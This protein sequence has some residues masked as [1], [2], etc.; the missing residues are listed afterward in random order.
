MVR[1]KLYPE[2][3]TKGSRKCGSKCCEVC[4]NVNE[5][6]TFTSTNSQIQIKSNSNHKF[7]YNGK[8][9]VS[10][11]TCNCCNKQYVAQPVD[12]FHF[13]WNNYESTCSKH[14]RGE[15]CMQQHLYEDFFSGNHNCYITD[16][17]VTFIN[18]IDL[19]SS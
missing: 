6:S 18:K 12:E 8:C 1:A 17:P 7:N 11:S 13:R 9:L 15:T 10:F 4:L 2:E 14:Q 5:T 16:V 19:S 3:K